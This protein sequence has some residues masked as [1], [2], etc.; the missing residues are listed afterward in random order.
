LELW[1]WDGGDWRLLDNSGPP[2]RNFAAATFDSDRNVLI[3]HG[4]LQGRGRDFAETWE[5]DGH[6]WRQHSGPGPGPLEG[7]G[8]AYDE[9][10]GQSVL[11]GGF[12]GLELKADTWLWDGQEW[13]L[14][15]SSGPSPR[16][17]TA[18]FYSPAAGAVFLYGGHAPVGNEAEDTG[19][20]WRWDGNAWSE[21]PQQEP[22]PGIL[23]TSGVAHD[24]ATGQIL[25]FGGSHV[26]RG[27][28][29]DIWAW[30]G[31]QWHLIPGQGMP[32]RSGQSVTY[33][34]GQGRFLMFGG[35]ERPGAPARDDSW[36][37]DGAFWRCVD[38][39]R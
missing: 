37:W 17:P 20:L 16:F 8:M 2:W 31:H 36:E 25:F 12:D 10:R 23:L 4:G 5:W 22:T 35:V 28:V 14:A 9:A 33:D 11:F 21:V 32:M 15:A 18:L 26:D 7:A 3:I 19:D 13:T 27:F 34:A 38:N 1:R 29:A 30:D 39:C 6:E 24:P